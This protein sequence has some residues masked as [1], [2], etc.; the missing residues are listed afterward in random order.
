MNKFD[1]EISPR[2]A[3][4]LL[5]SLY[6]YEKISKKVSTN[7]LKDF[8]QTLSKIKRNPNLQIR[9]NEVR[10][11]PLNN[12]LFMLHFKIYEKDNLVV[13]Y[14]LIHTS[15]NPNDYWVK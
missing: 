2:V 11:I 10:C 15:L 14:A 3:K 5:N 8:K 9:Y 6:Y 7:F 1:I 13:I 12:Y 4:D